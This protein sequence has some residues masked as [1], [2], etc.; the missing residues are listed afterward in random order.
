M[1]QEQGEEREQDEDSVSW[2]DLVKSVEPLSNDVDIDSHESESIRADVDEE[3][4]S[5]ESPEEAPNVDNSIEP[6]FELPE[7][8][9]PTILTP[10]APNLDELIQNGDE[11]EDECDIDDAGFPFCDFS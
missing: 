2:D 11:N 6:P 8:A 10:L 5:I 4:Q 3:E 1:E 7:I 9:I